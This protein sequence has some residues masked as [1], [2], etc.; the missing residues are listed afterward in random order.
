MPFVFQEP[1]LLS[2]PVLLACVLV[3]ALAPAAIAQPGT[4]VHPQINLTSE[5][6]AW[7]DAHPVVRHVP[8]PDYAPVESYASSGRPIGI[9]T[10]Y[11]EEAAARLGMRIERVGASTW[12]AAMDSIREGAADL[13]T[14]IQ[15]TEARSRFMVFTH[16]FLSV[17]DV[18]LVRKE[19]EGKQTLND[20]AGRTVALVDRYAANEALR[21]QYPDVTYRV[22]PDVQTGLE[23]TSFGSVDGMVLSLP[24]A[25]TMIERTQLTNL[26][27]GSETG[28]VYNLRF[29]IRDDIPI[30]RDI[31]DKALG[32]MTASTHKTIY[33]RWISL[34][35]LTSPS[36]DR[37]A[38]YPLLL[39]LGGLVVL[40][41]IGM[42]WNGS[43]QHEVKRRTQELQEA[44]AKAEEMNRLKSA[45]LAN[46]NHE[47]RTPLT[48]IIGFSETLCEQ[49]MDDGSH[50]FLRR[51]NESGRRLLHAL[52]SIL[53]LSQ[54]E[55]GSMQLEPR[56]LDV[57]Q[58]VESIVDRFREQAAHEDL[59]LDIVIS[60]TPVQAYADAAAFRRVLSNLLSNAIKFTEAG[61]QVR[62]CIRTDET[63]VIIDVEDTGIGIDPSFVPKL[64]DAFE[65][66]STGMSRR[67]EGVGLGLA[68]ARNLTEMM[69]GS[70]ALDSEKETGTRFTI[71]IPR[72]HVEAFV[73]SASGTI[74]NGA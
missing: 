12:S 37:S 35:A 63:D 49:E 40:L 2:W 54:L 29:G 6:R 45:F 71:R 68:I 14:A 22:V 41:G 9:A 61:G 57:V 34:D 19:V 3:G 23:E 46:M 10:D 15:K 67:F 28:Y 59:Q 4:D 55:A 39:I 42:A 58:E 1:R 72:F 20:L 7:I 36:E 11:L 21:A 18:L 65:Q 33:D 50:L 74:T 44:K 17:S 48:S 13:T 70:I 64:Y 43:L 5:E 31:L 25:S 38:W 27:V 73:Q 53:H 47:F 26:R 66:E 69:N 30:L 8:I 32:S 16:P 51:I 52:D 56:R 60:D 24:V 62:I